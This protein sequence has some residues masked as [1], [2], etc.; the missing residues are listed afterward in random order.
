MTVARHYKK[1]V[2]VS[3][4]QQSIFCHPER[5]EGS[6]F[7]AHAQNDSWI[8]TS[9]APPRNDDGGLNG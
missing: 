3:A 9:A 6:R 7:F 5:S 1:C 4:A 8:A 2:A